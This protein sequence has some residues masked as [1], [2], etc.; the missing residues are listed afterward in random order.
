VD[1]NPNH[2]LTWL[3]ILGDDH[4]HSD[5]A[6]AREND[7]VQFGNQD[8]YEQTYGVNW[9]AIW[10]QSGYSNTSLAV[11]GTRF[12][13]DYFEAGSGGLVFKN[14]STE[15]AVKL[16]QLNHFRLH[17]R[18]TL[19]FGFEVK[20]WRHT[21]ANVYAEYSD[22]LGNTTPAFTLDDQ[23]RTEQEGAFLNY[24]VTL[25]PRLVTTLGW[26]ADYFRYQQRLYYAPRLAFT[27]QLSARTSL[28]GTTGLY[29][30]NLPLVLLLQNDTQRNLEALTAVH[31]ILGWQHRL[32]ENTKLTLEVY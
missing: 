4:S 26:R 15:Q 9:R 19:E 16:R 29:Y 3:A 10:N 12:K 30:Q 22:L 25:W 23:I 28:H 24:Q 20:Q 8:I 21:Y 5:Q 13:E 7:M 31:Y 11:N 18:H 17:A 32:T 27:Y 1:L 14:R 2:Q 6:I